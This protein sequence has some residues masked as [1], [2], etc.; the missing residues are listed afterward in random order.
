[1]LFF[2]F[3]FFICVP[4]TPVRSQELTVE[5]KILAPEVELQQ[6]ATSVGA[7]ADADADADAHAAAQQNRELQEQEQLYA[8][9]LSKQQGPFIDLLGPQLIR[10]DLLNE[11]HAELAAPLTNEALSNAKVVG[12]Y[13]SADWCGP[14]RQ[15]T[16]ELVKFRERIS[17]KKGYK[18]GEFQIV[19]ISRCRDPEAY[20]QY[21]AEMTNFLALPYDD[22]GIGEH[23]MSKYRLQ[24]IPAFVLLD[25][26]GM[27]INKDG[28]TKVIEDKT[29][30]GFPWRSPLQN[31]IR[32]VPS[33]IRKMI[34]NQVKNLKYQGVKV[35]KTAFGFGQGQ[36]QG[37]M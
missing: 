1:M 27:I 9:Q 18:N 8:E 35:V 29:G 33:T 4:L 5:D 6:Q 37:E 16:P 10:L 24:G 3:F 15:F 13:F 36:G 22:G 31:I 11:T 21:Y 23:L 25:D 2:F 12:L 7:D 28:R 32:L 17:K 26:S 30:V 19:F 20:M 14:C 34:K